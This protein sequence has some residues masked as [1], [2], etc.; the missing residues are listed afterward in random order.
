MPV[1]ADIVQMTEMY[2]ELLAIRA[3]SDLFRLE[4]A[5]EIQERVFFHNTG[6]DQLPGLIVMSI[7]DL[8]ELDLDPE[9][10]RL[11]VLINANDE[12]QTFIIEDL[13]GHYLALHLIQKLSVD[14]VVKDSSYDMVSGS[15]TVPGRTAAVFVDY[16]TPQERLELLIEDIQDLVEAGLLNQGQGNSLVVKL[17]GAIDNLDRGKTKVAVNQITAFIN[18]VTSLIDEGVLS[19]ENGQALI[20]L[21]ADIIAQ[22]DMEY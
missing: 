14:E 13:A 12:P 2:Q 19:A 22:I 4:T 20:D 21:A 9:R 3:S 17:Q 5:A 10:E 15:F 7:S 1:S 18:E 11:V 8:V 16:A 6:P